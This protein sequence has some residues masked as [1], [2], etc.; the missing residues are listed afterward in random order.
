L[1]TKRGWN[2]PHLIGYQESHDEE[3]LMYK[4]LTFGNS[5]N[6]SHNAKDLNVALRRDG[7]ATAFWAMMPGP[8]MIWQFG[9]LGYD[10]SITWCPSNNTVPTPYPN[11]QCRTDAKPPAGTILLSG[12]QNYLYLCEAQPTPS[13]RTIA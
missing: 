6:G 4:N 3:R 8:K 9:E 10:Y 11:S 13:R 5:A 7:M 12:R 2:Q 1:F